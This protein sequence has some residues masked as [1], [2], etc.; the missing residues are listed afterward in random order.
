VEVALTALKEV[1]YREGALERVAP[2]V[3][4]EAEENVEAAP[5]LD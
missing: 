5:P 4:A 3:A 2:E 1:L